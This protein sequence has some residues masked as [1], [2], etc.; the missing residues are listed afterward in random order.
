MKK[1][2]ADVKVG[3][4]V[5][6]YMSLSREDGVAFFF[7]YGTYVGNEVPP[8]EGHLSFTSYLSGLRR[9]NPKIVL[10]GGEVVWGC[11]CWWGPEDEVKAEIATMSKV[12]NVDILEVRKGNIPPEA[13]KHLPPAAT[14]PPRDG[15]FWGGGSSG[16]DFWS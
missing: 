12:I 10:D 16:G 8:N 15:G 9:M 4:R 14:Q 6:A 5:G 7:G 13:R 2:M 11:E 1:A 3:D